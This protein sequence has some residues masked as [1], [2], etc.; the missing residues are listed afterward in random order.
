M[1]ARG[2]VAF[3]AAVGDD[4]SVAQLRVDDRSDLIAVRKGSGTVI[5]AGPFRESGARAKFDGSD[6]RRLSFS[7]GRKDNKVQLRVDRAW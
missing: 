7:S 6:E 5:C 1:L 2:D 3:A 4:V